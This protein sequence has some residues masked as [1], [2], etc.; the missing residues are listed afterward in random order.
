MTNNNLLKI[1]SLFN[2]KTSNT[3]FKWS[4]SNTD[5]ARHEAAKKLALYV[6]ANRKDGEQISLF[7]HSHG[8]NVAI[9]AANI[10]IKV[11]GVDASQINIVALN[12]PR[13]SD[14]SLKYSDV[15]LYSVSIANHNDLV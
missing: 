9:E 14:I 2:N 1:G 6:M 8:G 10:L 7:G 3:G 13:Q 12:T 4:G 15:N 11:H 5:K